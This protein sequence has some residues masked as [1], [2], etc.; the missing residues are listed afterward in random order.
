M[1]I[2]LHGVLN[3]DGTWPN[4]L[5]LRIL[6]FKLVLSQCV[7]FYL[8]SSFFPFGPVSIGKYLVC[9]GN[10]TW[11]HLINEREHA[12]QHFPDSQWCMAWK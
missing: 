7:N 5:P 8:V 1:F 11:F 10:R 3:R 4:C 12:M 9:V 6:I 2:S